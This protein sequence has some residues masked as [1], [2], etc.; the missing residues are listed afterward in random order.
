L[1][2][3]PIKKK[4][5]YYYNFTHSHFYYES[6]VKIVVDVALLLES[7]LLFLVVV[8]SYMIIYFDL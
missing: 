8:G 3:E 1:K 2:I 5:S 7:I 4:C 6:V